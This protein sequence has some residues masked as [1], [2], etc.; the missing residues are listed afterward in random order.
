MEEVSL[1]F[2]HLNGRIFKSL[3]DQNVAK[4]R[5]VS[6]FWRIRLDKQ[7]FL[8]IRIIQA[9]VGQFHKIG[10]AWNM[11]FKTA[12]TKTI[13]DL[14]LA[15]SEFYKKGNNLKYY[16]GLTPIHVAA[17]TGNLKLLQSVQDKTHDKQP[18]DIVGIQPEDA[19]K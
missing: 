4:C 18:K 5:E 13:M 10:E 12:P 15:V 1:R 16:E 6:R 9:T 8:Q 11:L 2:P 19:G 17:G 3:D 14:G 7:K